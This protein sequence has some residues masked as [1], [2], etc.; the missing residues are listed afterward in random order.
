[1]KIVFEKPSISDYLSLRERAGTGEKDANRARIALR[2]SLLTVSIYD[3]DLL[4]GFGRVAGDGGITYIICDIM[5]D[6][7][8]HRRGYGNQIMMEINKYL[9]KHT[10]EDSYVCLIAVAPADKL[11]NRYNFEYLPDQKCGMVRNQKYL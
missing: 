7:K 8:Y 1:M 6:K 5:V 9:D 11:Y 3:N 2:N 10:H 4:V